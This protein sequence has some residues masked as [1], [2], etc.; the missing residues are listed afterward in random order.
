MSMRYLF[1]KKIAAK[2]SPNVFDGEVHPALFCYGE[3]L[4]K[5]GENHA[6]SLALG[7]ILANLEGVVYQEWG[8]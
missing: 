6:P 3:Y 8:R 2:H 4:V 7:D 1:V 5:S